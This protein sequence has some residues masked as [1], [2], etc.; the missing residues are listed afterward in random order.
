MARV[1]ILAVEKGKGVLFY[2]DLELREGNGTLYLD[3]KIRTDEQAKKA[4]DTAFSL[5]EIKKEDIFVHSQ[6]NK[7]QCLCGSSLGL[8][9]Y[10]GM[11]ALLS[12]LRFKSKIFATGSIDKKGNVI[13]VGCL[14]EKIKAVLGKADKLLVP[15]NQG[16][17]IT[18]M[19]VVEVANIQEA[20]E[21]ALC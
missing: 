6:N 12:G 7:S 18:G 3:S 8:P 1:P 13:S 20:T 10:L 17:P 21:I 2:L 5:L 14:A 11:Y 15:K 16:L 4:I 19:D 9:V